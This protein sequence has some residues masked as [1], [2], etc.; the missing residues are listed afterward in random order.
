M[1]T[2]ALQ[3]ALHGGDF[4]R[5]SDEWGQLDGQVMGVAL[6]GLERGKFGRQTRNDEL[7]EM[8]GA[9]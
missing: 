5:S 9:L 8:T 2:L 4:P 6:E 7:V 1:R 3:E